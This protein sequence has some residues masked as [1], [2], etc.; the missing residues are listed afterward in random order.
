MATEEDPISLAVPF[1]SDSSSDSSESSSSSSGSASAS[2]AEQPAAAERPARQARAASPSPVHDKPQR[3]YHIV[4]S[5]P[6]DKD[7]NMRAPKEFSKQQFGELLLRLA[8]SVFKGN[9]KVLK[10]SVFSELH[11]SGESHF[12]V[13]FLADRPFR[14]GA[15]K[16]ALAHERI[17]VYFQTSHSYYWSALVYLS[18]A[19]PEKPNVD[20][21][22]FLSPGHPPVIDCLAD[23]PRGANKTMKDMVI[24]WLGDLGKV[25][26]TAK[27]SRCMEHPEF[28]D[29][30]VKHKLKTKSA[31]MAALST[32]SGQ[33]AEAARQY[34][35]RYSARLEQV[36][37]FAWEVHDAP[38]IELEQQKSCWDMVVD[39]RALDCTCS[40]RWISLLEETIAF[41]SVDFPADV[42]KNELPTVQTIR[43]AHQTALQLGAGKYRNCF[44][45]GPRNGGKTFSIAPLG[46]IFGARWTF[47]RPAGSSNFPLSSLIDKKIMVLQDMRVTSLKLSFDSLLVLFEGE[48]V[49]IPLPKNIAASDFR[50]TAKCPIFV[51]AGEKFRIP[52]A[53]AFREQVDMEAQNAMMAARFQHFFFHR[54]RPQKDL[55]PCPPCPCCYSQWVVVGAD[56]CRSLA[57]ADPFVDLEAADSW[58]CLETVLCCKT[59]HAFVW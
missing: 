49:T 22:P 50:Y 55:V 27:K 7:S 47:I 38:A 46:E 51:S 14:C 13:P 6:V 31:A 28:A 39:A 2:A 8:E 5:A 32:M 12:H 4:F 52:A 40:G 29:W 48:P 37:T 26:P 30:L 36:I 25:P 53:E 16:R 59:I 19:S 20:A 33:A 3:L 42:P 43:H 18:V 35:Y 57:P 24:A 56:P 1:P 44:C 15:L 54:S 45:Y 17:Y 58:Q 11:E 23:I 10:M 21:N 34:M 41:Q 9:N